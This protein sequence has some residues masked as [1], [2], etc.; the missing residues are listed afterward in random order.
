MTRGS[1]IALFLNAIWISA[2]LA[3]VAHAILESADVTAR[4]KCTYEEGKSIDRAAFQNFLETLTA[5]QHS[6]EPFRIALNKYIDAAPVCSPVQV[7]GYLEQGLLVGLL[8]LTP[9]VLPWGI[10][11]A[12]KR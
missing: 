6:N 2:V 10:R 3:F 4:L 9:L 11:W 1:R 7:Y 8:L 5:E 12:F